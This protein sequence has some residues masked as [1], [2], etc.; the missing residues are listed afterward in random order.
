M[1]KTKRLKPT[2]MVT[3]L[4]ITIGIAFAFLIALILNWEA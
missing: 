4:L 2:K 3:D 1:K